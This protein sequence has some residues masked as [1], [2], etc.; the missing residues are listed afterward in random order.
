[1]TKARNRAAELLEFA[2]DRLVNVYGE[3]PNVD[4]VLAMR[5]EA[6]QLRCTCDFA[7]DSCAIHGRGSD[8]GQPGD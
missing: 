3:N 6:K 7:I 5:D 4:F 8:K 1:M 2:A